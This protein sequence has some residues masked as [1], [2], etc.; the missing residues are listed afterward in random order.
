MKIQKAAVLWNEGQAGKEK[1]FCDSL[2]LRFKVIN[3][4]ASY[5]IVVD[6]KRV[7][8]WQDR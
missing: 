2:S 4:I 5:G 7:G 6:A 3:V 1:E 8:T